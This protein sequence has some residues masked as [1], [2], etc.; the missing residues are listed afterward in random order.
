MSLKKRFLEKYKITNEKNIKELEY[1]DEDQIICPHCKEPVKKK[2]FKIDKKGKYVI[3]G[4]C[5]GK[6]SISD[7]IIYELSEDLFES[8]SD[9]VKGKVTQL[10]S[11]A[12]ED[13]DIEEIGDL[14]QR[15][16]PDKLKTSDPLKQAKKGTHDKVY[17]LPK[18]NK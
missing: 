5:E 18:K 14:G 2:E 16:Q 12:I 3:H 13:L 17:E 9:F 8:K 4:K 11:K 15:D 1:S 10:I 7:N 6:I